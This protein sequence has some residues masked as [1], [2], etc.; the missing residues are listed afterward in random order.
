MQDNKKSKK[1]NQSGT[2]HVPA[3]ITHA[4][5]NGKKDS[6]GITVASDQNVAAAQKSVEETKK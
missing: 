3:N 4:I 2:S 6:R 1:S 5:A